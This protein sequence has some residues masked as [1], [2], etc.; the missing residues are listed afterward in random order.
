MEITIDDFVKQIP[1]TGCDGRA[2]PNVEVV[3][4]LYDLRDQLYAGNWEPI[5]KDI[6]DYN[7]RSIVNKILRVT[8]RDLAI[9]RYILAYETRHGATTLLKDEKRNNIY[10]VSQDRNSASSESG[11]P[12][13]QALSQESQ[14]P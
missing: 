13:A 14:H 3:T 1:T 9:I 4:V 12:A 6:E 2:L 11:Q 5:M 7:R 8:G 10:V